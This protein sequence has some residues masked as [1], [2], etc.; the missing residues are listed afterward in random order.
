MAGSVTVT[1]PGAV[2]PT[3]HA[4]L[5]LLG[6]S[7]GP[8]V[9][10]ITNPQATYANLEGNWQEQARP[11]TTP[12]NIRVGSKLATAEITST[13]VASDGG[14]WDAG[15]T[16]EPIVEA[17]IAL[18]AADGSYPVAFTWGSL[19]SSAV[20]TETGHWRVDSLEIVSQHRQPGTNNISQATVTV[21]LK[22]VSDVI[23]NVNVVSTDPS[24]PAGTTTK[25]PP[26]PG[27]TKYTVKQGDTLYSISR[28]IYGTPSYWALIGIYNNIK[29]PT[30]LTPGQVIVVESSGG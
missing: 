28:K 11:G 8:V 2:T 27:V 3:P 22:E 15:N 18:A 4:Q 20:L 1:V 17:L 24:V 16:V 23:P 7:Q 19:D 12:L 25:V 13:I 5:T 21:T 29:N 6:S 10:P 9:L 30:N 14:T 26:T